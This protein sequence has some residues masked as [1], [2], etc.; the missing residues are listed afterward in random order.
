M[1][2][3]YK[4]EILLAGPYWIRNLINLTFGKR[5]LLSRL[6]N[7]PLI[8][9]G[10]DLL[11]FKDD[12]ILFLP[13]DNTIPIN[14]DLEGRSDMVLPL[15]LFLANFTDANARYR[16]QTYANARNQ[17]TRDGWLCRLWNL[18]AGYLFC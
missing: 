15:L 11:L 17:S 16:Q 9:N 7:L 4:K 12:D 1:I 2:S 18:C 8:G 13:R 5:Q 14:Q 6:S 10:L 3:F